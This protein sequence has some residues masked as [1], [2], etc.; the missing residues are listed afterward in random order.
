MPAQRTLCIIK[1]NAMEQRKQAQ[2]LQRILDE[3]FEV[4]ALR[5]LWLSRPQVE[6]FYAIH[7]GR[8]FFD[9]LCAFM[10]RGPIIVAALERE[11]AVAHWRNVIGATDPAKAAPNT[12]RALYAT[13]V[14]ENA[15]HGSDSAENG[16]IECAYFFTGID[17]L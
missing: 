15:V 2:I 4:V 5:K 10:C 16:L 14:T 3:G 8:P 17:L 1:P 12:L 9:A 13:S 11:D 6:G 7:R